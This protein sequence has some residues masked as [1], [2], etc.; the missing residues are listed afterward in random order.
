MGL[1][2][3][4]NIDSIKYLSIEKAEETF[5]E[6][7]NVF[8]DY[9]DNSNLKLLAVKDSAIFSQYLDTHLTNPLINN[10][11]LDIANTSHNIMQLRYID[12]EGIEKIR[13]DRE[14]YSS[15][16]F[17]VTHDKLQNKKDRYYFKEIM[18]IKEAAI[19]L[20][21][22]DLNIEHGTIQR[23]IKPVLR[24]GTPV[25]H[26]GENVGILIINLFMED[27]L[28]DLITLPIFDVHIFNQDGD[29]LVDSIHTHAWSKYLEN[30]Q[31]IKTHFPQEIYSKILAQHEYKSE[32]L[33]SNKIFLDNE[34][35]LIMVIQ[36]K[37]RH[38]E[39]EATKNFKQVFWIMLTVLLFSFPLSYL[40]S[41]TPSKLKREVDLQKEDQDVLLSLFDISDSVLFKWNNDETWT[42]P[43]VSKSVET[44]LGYSQNDFISNS[45]TYAECIH[46]NDIEHVFEEVQQAKSNKLYF[47]KHDPYRIKTKDG[48][49]KWIL[50]YTVVQRD[51]TGNILNFVG[52]LN[53]ITEL[54]NSEIA[55]ERLSIT[56]HLTQA[57]NRIH[58]DNILQQQYQRFVRNKEEC[59]VILIDIDL[60]KSVN[61]TYGHLIGDSVL[62]E[63]TNILKSKIRFSDILGR[64]G[65]EEFL[66]I[67]PHTNL[68]TTMLIAEKLRKTI[69]EYI[70]TTMK[71]ET[72]SFGVACLSKAG[73]IGELV[74]IADKGLYLAKDSGRNCVK[75]IQD[76][77]Q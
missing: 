60:F 11:F 15:E 2:Y 71:N 46:K 33:Y 51:E 68:E 69:S 44:L 37:N 1:I 24:L 52:Y 47:F 31:S 16:A 45:I 57:Y 34:E 5:M 59:S 63:F 6:R 41:K 20:S 25:I 39:E 64:W 75:T 65:G 72:A 9:I 23:P 38:L 28:N 73:S 50:D 70:F 22:L 54:K 26:N 32:K 76:Q 77:D 55:L 30:N 8:H 12:K 58:T 61:D 4:F 74:T 21:K 56:D 67:L 17:I 48:S 40:F 10:F 18:Q 49:Y 53:D 14:T 19:W 7:K 43:Y 13:I 27:F 29:I 62:I 3:K 36:A 66:V 35:D 42:V